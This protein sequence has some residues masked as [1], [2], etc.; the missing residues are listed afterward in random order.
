MISK[1]AEKILN[2]AFNEAQLRS[3]AFLTL[4]HLLY[5]IAHDKIGTEIL[6]NSGGIIE[7]IK[8]DLNDYLGTLE[9]A[10]TGQEIPIQTIAFQRILQQAIVHVHSAEKKEMDIGDMLVAL[11][12]E[13]DSQARYILEK[14]GIT[15]LDV[16]N[17][18]SHG[19]SK[20]LDDDLLDDEDFEFPLEEEVKETKQKIQDKFLE[21]FAIDMIDEAKKGKYDEL[22][23]REEELKRTI[24]ILCR[25]QKNNPLHVGDAGV[26]KTAIARGLAQKIVNNQ[27]P[28]RLKN[29]Y[30]YAIDMGLLLAGTK[31][32][33]DFEERIK[34]LLGA[35]K[36][37]EKVII[38]IDEIHTII[39]AGSVSG[40]SMDASN[41]LK[42]VLASGELRCIGSTTYD[43]FRQHF[44]KDRALLRRFQKVEIIEPSVEDTINILKGLKERYEKFHNVKYSQLALDASARLSEKFLRDR[45]LP[46]KAIDLMDEAGANISIY[47]PERKVVYREDI[48]EL[49]A[50][51]ARIPVQAVSHNE[52]ESLKNL[53]KDLVKLVYGQDEAVKKIANAVKRHRAGMGSPEKPVGSFLFAGPTGVGKTELSKRLA[54]T[55]GIELIRFD[56]SEYMEKHSVSRFIGS[57]PGYVGFDQGAQLTDSIRKNP[58]AVLLLDEIEKAHP[59]ILNTMLQVMDNA[60]ITDTTGKTADFRNI[61]VIMTSNV[62]SREMS[63]AMIGFE[64]KD[65]SEKN[66]MNAVKKTFLPEFRNRLDAIVLFNP[67]N[68]QIVKKIVSKF[69]AE[70]K[71]QLKDKKVKISLSSAAMN[72]FAKKGYEPEFGARPMS[73]LIQEKLKNPIVDEVLFGKLQEGGSVKVDYK[74]NKLYL[75]FLSAK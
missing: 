30:M 41:L 66:P 58:H 53:E 31:F 32:R 19:I 9:K 10:K 14:Q 2:D 44:E 26:G 75:D 21:R 71:G 45:H 35:F 24:E 29:Y 20:A 65:L 11:F 62:G 73:R 23:G 13:D 25:R 4:E 61:I 36:E 28:E 48:E 63:Q 6:F 8:D 47:H 5:S 51:I 68:L 69:I 50:R 37:K 43:E 64:R 59:D 27:V 54:E 74:E 22:I 70:L 7:E 57:P 55:L 40:G 34:G 49:I 39:G 12:N 15:R 56:M 52:K 1:D 16:V 38:F 67:L 46:D 33:G 42:P 72:Y 17:Y 3:H 18:I 60:S